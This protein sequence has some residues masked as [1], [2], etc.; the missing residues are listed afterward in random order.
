MV[1]GVR[2]P[3]ANH[4]RALAHYHALPAKVSAREPRRERTA[5]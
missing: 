3:K 5:L 1:E 4:M 2:T